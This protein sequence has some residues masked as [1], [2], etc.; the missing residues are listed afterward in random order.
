MCNDTGRSPR[1]EASGNRFLPAN[2]SGAIWRFM[3]GLGSRKRH[4]G[5]RIPRRGT[6]RM[7]R[8]IAPGI[9]V[10]TVLNRRVR[11][12]LQALSVA[13]LWSILANAGKGE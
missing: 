9:G 10:A 2:I 1:C 3:H 7:R 13:H 5:S 12:D 6:T 11:A 8:A 4:R